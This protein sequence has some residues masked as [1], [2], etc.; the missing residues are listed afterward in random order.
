MGESRRWPME[1]GRRASNSDPE[2]RRK[3]G[4]IQR[5]EGGAG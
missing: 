1:L 4:E 5:D 3:M 2:A